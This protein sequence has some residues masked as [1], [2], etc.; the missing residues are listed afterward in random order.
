MKIGEFGGK[1]TEN[2]SVDVITGWLEAL[3]N[4]EEDECEKSSSPHRKARLDRAHD[5]LEALYEICDW[6]PRL[7]RHQNRKK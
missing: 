1:G 7:T 3:I 4:D 6:T 2:Y 5:A